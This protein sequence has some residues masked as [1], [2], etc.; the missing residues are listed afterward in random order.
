MNL[1]FTYSFVR[2][3]N[4]KLIMMVTDVCISTQS[5]ALGTLNLKATVILRLI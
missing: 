5:S 2:P 1:S 3:A 4:P